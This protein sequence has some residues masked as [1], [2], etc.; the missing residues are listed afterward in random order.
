MQVSAVIPTCNRKKRL[1]FLL[2]CLNRSEHNLC[3]VTIVDSGEDHLMESEISSFLNLHIEY[4]LSE[5]SV[6]IQRNIGIKAA[7]SEWILLCDDDI[8]VP[9]DYLKKLV[10]HIQLQQQLVAVSGLFLQ[11]ERNEWTAK[12]SI[13]S[14][15]FLLWQYIFKLSI[16]GEINCANNIITK[17]IKKYYRRK[18]NHI[19]KAGWPVITNFSGDYF[20]T[21]LYSLGAALIQRSW[22][23]NSPFD[24]ALDPYGIGEHYGVIADFPSQQIHVLNNA[25]VYHHHEEANRLQ[26]SLQY[27]RRVLALDYF[28]QIKKQLKHI[29]KIWLLWSLFGNLLVFTFK[30]NSIMMKANYKAMRAIFLN[31]NPYYKAHQHSKKIVQPDFNN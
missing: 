23:I 11:K 18:G 13:T 24:E 6:C 17:P 12:Y 1:L 16:W 22:L 7:K 5:K 28:R 10:K 29:K 25:F 19:S 21:P 4:L 9:A 3:E 2:D 31:K 14:S 20:T 26:K 8:E 15:A 30:K 27:Y